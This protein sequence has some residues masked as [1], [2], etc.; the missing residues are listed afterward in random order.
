MQHH[1]KVFNNVALNNNSEILL[2]LERDRRAF[3]KSAAIEDDGDSTIQI[4]LSSP[5]SSNMLDSTLKN[6][7]CNTNL[8]SG[9]DV[10]TITSIQRPLS[11]SSAMT[12]VNLNS[13]ANILSHNLYSNNPACTITKSFAASLNNTVNS[14]TAPLTTDFNH[15]AA[16]TGIGIL[17]TPN[18]IQDTLDT[19][20]TL[21]HPTAIKH[22][23]C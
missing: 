22:E 13:G 15:L 20:T 14:S 3:R 7:P 6:V 10:S 21:I 12:S 2:R 16:L 19:S 4:T 18:L 23:Q 11:E 9:F 5:S 17:S 1:D 8:S